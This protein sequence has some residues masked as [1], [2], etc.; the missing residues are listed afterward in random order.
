[1][2]LAFRTGVKKTAPCYL[3][4]ALVNQEESKVYTDK[5]EVSGWFMD[6]HIAPCG[7]QCFGGGAKG[8]EGIA[9][10]KAGKLH[11]IKN[12]PCEACK[13]LNPANG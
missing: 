10:Y 9:L 13:E 1:M 7:A 2:S 3:C 4:G 6:T 12:K 5:G 11:G 8:S